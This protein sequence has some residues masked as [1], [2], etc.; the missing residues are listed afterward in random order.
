[1]FRKIIAG[2]CFAALISSCARPVAQFTYTDTEY[3]VLDTIRFENS[4]EKAESFFWDFGDGQTS[5][6]ALPSHRY[7]RS[8][9]Y[10]ITLRVTKGK[11]T[12]EVKKRVL[13]TLPDLCLVELKTDFGTMVLELYEDTP[14]HRDNFVKMVEEGYLNDL[15]FH[16]V[17]EGFMIQGGDPKSRNA[18]EGASLGSGGPGYT[19]ANEIAVGHVHVKGALAAAR[20]PDEYNPNRESSGSQFYIVHG[21]KLNEKML[22]SFEARNGMNYTE[23]QRKMYLEYGGTPFLDGQYTVFGRVVEG[24]DIIDLIAKSQKDSRDRPVEDV[25]MNLEFID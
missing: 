11:K 3:Q 1:M 21:S 22:D 18:K 24:F 4:S 13:V 15:L 5:E 2:F 8:G 12:D 19:I 23:E 14:I 20:A 25:R 7:D 10:E 16:R 6:D 17:I 9:N